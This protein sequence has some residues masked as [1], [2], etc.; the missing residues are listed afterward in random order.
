MHGVKARVIKILLIQAVNEGRK[1][2]GTGPFRS[3]TGAGLLQG[4][5]LGLPRDDAAGSLA[6]ACCRTCAGGK[7][8]SK[9]ACLQAIPRQIIIGRRV[10][11]QKTDVPSNLR[12]TPS[13]FSLGAESPAKDKNI[14]QDLTPGCADDLHLQGR[15]GVRGISPG[16]LGCH[17]VSVR[18][19]FQNLRTILS[20]R[21][22]SCFLCLSD[23]GASG[24]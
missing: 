7:A 11:G 5:V 14:W 18:L 16:S 19:R 6:H 9:I 3:W 22:G 17:D 20:F 15:H 21:I 12:L 13:V 1:V 4:D 23:M 24:G 10:P 2:S 8:T